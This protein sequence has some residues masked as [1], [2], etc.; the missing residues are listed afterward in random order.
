MDKIKNAVKILNKKYKINNVDIAIVVGSGLIESAPK[1]NNV[2]KVSYDELG[3]PKSKVKGH[4][5]N[6][7]FGVLLKSTP[8]RLRPS[9]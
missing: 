6:F 8:R 5:G 2:V 4:S 9:I 1:L 3:L 7:I